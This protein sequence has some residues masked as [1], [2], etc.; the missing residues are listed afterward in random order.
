MTRWVIIFALWLTGCQ[1]RPPLGARV[2]L[3]FFPTLTHGAA[4]VGIERGDLAR[5][6]Q[7]APLELSAFSSGPEAIEALF[8]GALDAC[9]VGPMPALSGFT[10]SRGQAL[11]IV[12]GAASGGAALVV[13]RGSGIDGA[14]STSGKKLAT[15]QIGNTQDVAL[16]AWL[17]ENGKRTNDRGGDVQVIPLHNADTLSL[18]KRGEIDGAWVPE[19]WVTRLVH[20]AN[21]QVLV[22]DRDYWAGMPTTLLV[23]SRPFLEARPD[24]VAKLVASHVAT[25]EWARDHSVEAL[26]LAAVAMQKFGGKPLPPALQAE[27][28]QRVELTTD[29]RPDQLQRFAVAA[30]TLG[31]L[32]HGFDVRDAIDSH[33]VA[34]KATP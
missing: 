26:A 33:F 9:Y 15:P 5:A 4:L 22:D 3:G 25:V 29:P 8:A 12:A 27:A 31:Y 10:R 14:A 21:G 20:E 28:W 24:L 34:S 6:L 11:V 19:P 32:D 1:A 23:V 7:P 13:R 17:R 16:R 18:M 2:R 30:L